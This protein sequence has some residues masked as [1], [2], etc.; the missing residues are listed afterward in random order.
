MESSPENKL[1]MKL[2]VCDVFK[3][4]CINRLKNVINKLLHLRKDA[5][6]ETMDLKCYTMGYIVSE[7]WAYDSEF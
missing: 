2:Q 4:F 7:K 6:I 5:S 1:W 3:G